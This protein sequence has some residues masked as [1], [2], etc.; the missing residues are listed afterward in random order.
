M[1][2]LP[3]SPP[4]S[5]RLACQLIIAS[6]L[7]GLV[8]LLPGVD[9]GRPGDEEI[10]FAITFAIVALFCGLTV[11]LVAKLY[12]GKR[13]ARWA[14]LA[15]LLFGWAITGPS[16]TDDFL[17]AP[18]LGLISGICIALEL[19]AA[20]LIFFGRNSPPSAGEED[21]RS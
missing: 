14:M 10:S 4:P 19:I 13:W 21:N 5:I 6:M 17:R 11:W 12:A 1:K 16:L 20:W 15:F 3:A 8:T 7:L 9:P 2:H 18:L